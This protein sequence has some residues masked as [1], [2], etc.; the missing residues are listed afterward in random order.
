VAD[1]SYRAAL[2]AAQDADVDPLEV[3]RM[4][5]R[6]WG[7]DRE[8]EVPP[9]DDGSFFRG[10]C[11]AIPVAIVLWVVLIWGLSIAAGYRPWRF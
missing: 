8:E 2:R 9:S 7:W 5:I 3:T 6:D 1:R 10:L 11:Y 4:Y